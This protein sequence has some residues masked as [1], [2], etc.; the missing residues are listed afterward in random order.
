[1][2]K[3]RPTIIIKPPRG[4]ASIRFRE[5]WSY[6]ALLMSLVR[7]RIKSE[8]DQQYLAYVWPV[9]RPVLMV[10]L[11]SAF[12]GLSNAR[13]GV[14]MPYPLYVYAGLALWFYFIEAVQQAATSL[15]QNAGLITKVYFP[16]LLVPVSAIMA[17]LYMFAIT[18]VPLTAMMIFFEAAPGMNFFLLPLVLLQVLVLI[19]GIGC[20]FAALGL[21]NRDWD[22]FLG[23]VLYIGLFVSPV[24]YSPDMFPEHVRPIF[25]LNPAVGMLMGF[26]AALF[27]GM[28]FP[29]A[30]WLYTWAFALI[31]TA[32][33]LLMFQRVEEHLSDRL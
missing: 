8:F 25:A 24:I 18:I 3:A 29:W 23:F 27:E 19:F 31:A 2:A 22:K 15:K 6:R 17:N 9:F 7:R 10:L 12:R 28:A 1:M 32:I 20:I 30:E 11:F 14:D 21:G 16:R 13:V 4:F 26:R 5:L 33:G